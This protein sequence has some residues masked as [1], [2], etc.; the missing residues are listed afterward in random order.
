[1]PGKYVLFQSTDLENIITESDTVEQAQNV[2]AG[3]M[4]HLNSFDLDIAKDYVAECWNE[5]WGNVHG[6]P[7]G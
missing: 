4:A 7:Y 1:M 6:G 5:L 2:V 3:L